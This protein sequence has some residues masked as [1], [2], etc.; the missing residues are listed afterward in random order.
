[1]PK[2]FIIILNWNGKDD[3]LTCLDSVQKLNYPNYH[4][5]VVD[6]GSTDGSADAGIMSG[7]DMHLSMGQSM[8][9][10]SIMTPLLSRILWMC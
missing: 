2:V 6:N 7:F 10:F 3:T 8:S 1:M 4:V 5:I 9:G